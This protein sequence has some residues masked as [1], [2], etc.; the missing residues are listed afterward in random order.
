M[1]V[2][3]RL[4]ALCLALLLTEPAVA[5][6]V[7]SGL[8]LPDGMI[9]TGEVFRRNGTSIPSLTTGADANTYANSVPPTA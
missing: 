9:V 1:G 8:L 2:R 4:V 6:Q 7:V 5:Q 3:R